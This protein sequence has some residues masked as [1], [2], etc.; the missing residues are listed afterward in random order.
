MANRQRAAIGGTEIGVKVSLAPSPLLGGGSGE[1][2]K[3]EYFEKAERLLG[4]LASQIGNMADKAAQREGAEAGSLAGMDPE[5]RKV[6]GVSIRAEA[7]NRA[8]LDAYELTMKNTIYRRAAEIE[9]AHKADPDGAAKAF[10]ALEAEWK[11]DGLPEL[12]PIVTAMV[13]RLKLG[14]VRGATRAAEAEASANRKAAF[15]QSLSARFSALHRASYQLGLDPE[16]DRASAGELEELRRDVTAAAARGDITAQAA[17]K[18]LAE[19]ESGVVSARLL[20][21]FDR[22]PDQASR[23]T[24]LTEFERGYSQGRGDLAKLDPK[25]A[26]RVR[27]A[28]NGRLRSETAATGQQVR[29]LGAEL[30]AIDKVTTDGVRPS[31][32]TM[33]ALR[34]QVAATGDD[35]LGQRFA[36][37]EAA[38]SLAETARKMRPAE[39]EAAIGDMDRQ[40]AEKGASEDALALRGTAAKLLATM[41][42][43]L[44]RDPLGWATR[45]G[46]LAVAPADFAAPLSLRARAD[47][48]ETVAAYYG[49]APV[50]LRPEERASLER[51]TAAGGEP[52]LAAARALADGFGARAPKVLGEVS[53]QAPV[54]AHTGALLASGASEGFALDVA[55]ALAM[56]ASPDFKAPKWLDKPGE[57]VGAA[58]GAETRATYGEAF[59]LLPDTA[60]AAEKTAQTGFYARAVRQ[61]HDPM[62]AG[63]SREAYRRTLQEAAGARFIDGTQFGGVTEI[64]GGWFGR[65][66][67]AKV[68]VPSNVRADRFADVL[69]AVDDKDLQ[70]QALGAGFTAAD[71][72]RARPVAVPGGYRFALGDPAGT[73]PRWIRSLDGGPFVLDLAAIENKLRAKLPDAYLGG[74]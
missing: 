34:A 62:L 58:Q 2:G 9:E 38:L 68:V 37:A 44:G 54:L 73:D 71:V 61:G 23:E 53:K 11:N 69:A 5:F 49:T 29:A 66:A 50:Y 63:E 72:R 25:S 31:D 28:M 42:T 55:D 57:K 52:M 35:A 47:Q 45:T 15:D 70:A 59:A 14:V 43:E 46:L 13:E 65:R 41:K 26:D 19:A 21:A 16:A 60:R 1:R 8:G 48:A 56:R 64:G 7:Y 30:N 17:S 74:R 6:D 36:R 3:I 22:L 4:Q 33:A 27:S 24:M 39:L 40:I 20:G 67:A 32:D 51:A 18:T 10:G 12:Q